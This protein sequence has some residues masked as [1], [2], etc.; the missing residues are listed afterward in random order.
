M[1]A[2]NKKLGYNEDPNTEIV[3]IT[4]QLK[5]SDIVSYYKDNIQN[6][7]RAFI[8]VG[9]KKKLP[10]KQLAKYGNIVELK[11]SDFYR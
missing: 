10:M 8:I 4:P 2:T 7:P 5:M 6:R 1:I 11:K 3:K 9:N